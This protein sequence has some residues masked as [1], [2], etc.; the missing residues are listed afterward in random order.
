M[1]WDWGVSE[2]ETGGPGWD[3]INLREPQTPGQR[4]QALSSDAR[5]FHLLT[6]W[7]LPHPTIFPVSRPPSAPRLLCPHHSA[8]PGVPQKYAVRRRGPLGAR[9][10][11]APRTAAG[12]YGG[13]AWAPPGLD[14]V[15]RSGTCPRGPPAPPLSPRASAAHRPQRQAQQR[16]PA[17]CQQ[18]PG[19]PGPLPVSAEAPR[20]GC[21]AAPWTAQVGEGSALV[22]QTPPHPESPPGTPRLPT[23]PTRPGPGV[24]HLLSFQIVALP[25]HP[26]ASELSVPTRTGLPPDPKAA[27]A[28]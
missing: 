4:R 9:A 12:C 15:C 6:S 26:A 16:D 20:G 1:R 23:T 17:K 2:P 11:C 25:R 7:C 13:P 27:R 21:A 24:A 18:P 5:F 22:L 19:C 14:G 3:Q 10:D 8:L 28:P